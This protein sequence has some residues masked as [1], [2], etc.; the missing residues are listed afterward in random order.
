MSKKSG[1]DSDVLL[2]QKKIDEDEG[3]FAEPKLSPEPEIPEQ[4][5]EDLVKVPQG[6]G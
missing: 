6:F 3:D 4:V 1:E 2:K 5:H